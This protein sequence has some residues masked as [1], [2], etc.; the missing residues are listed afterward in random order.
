M[1]NNQHGWYEVFVTIYTLD[2]IPKYS[3]ATNFRKDKN[4]KMGSPYIASCTV[5][6]VPPTSWLLEFAKYVPPLT[7]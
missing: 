5:T 7:V 2:N 3:F 6:Q 1:L 4:F